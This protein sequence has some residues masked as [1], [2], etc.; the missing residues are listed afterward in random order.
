[1]IKLSLVNHTFS[2]ELCDIIRMFFGKVDIEIINDEKALVNNQGL[3]LISE[4]NK[5]ESKSKNWSK[6][7]F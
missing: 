7:R 3:L 2:Y 6:A 5:N 4:I 1:M